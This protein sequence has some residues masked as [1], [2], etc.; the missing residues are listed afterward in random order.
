MKRYGSGD[1]TQEIKA[2]T[3]IPV[4]V[5]PM[6]LVSGPE[7]VISCSKAGVVGSFPT[8]NARTPEVL[9]SWLGE[10]NAALSDESSP[11]VAP[12]AANL[13]VHPTNQRLQTDLD[14]LIKHRV[15]FVIASVG[16][17]APIV[18]AIKDYDGIVFSDVATVRHA[19][20]KLALMA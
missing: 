4:I 7:L 16:S 13:I 10:I 1:L 14:L 19:R 2:K 17:P 8:L 6:F 3:R 9:D 12:Y 15:G 20:R 5:G 18:A 11:S